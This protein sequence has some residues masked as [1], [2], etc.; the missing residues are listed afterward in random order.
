MQP[1]IPG[2]GSLNMDYVKVSARTPKR[3]GL[4]VEKGGKPPLSKILPEACERFGGFGD[5]HS[6]A[7]SGVFLRGKENDFVKALDSLAK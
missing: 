6:V 4:L 2:F 5:G 1:N 3:L 7:A